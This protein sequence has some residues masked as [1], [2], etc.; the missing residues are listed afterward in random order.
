MFL[1]QLRCALDD[2]LATWSTSPE[3][4]FNVSFWRAVPYDPARP[5]READG[6]WYVALSMDG[7]NS[8]AA[9][10]KL[11]CSEGGQ[12]VLWRSPALRGPDADWQLAGPVLGE[13]VG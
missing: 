12:L 10:Q 6:N 4:L 5:W 13:H 2:D 9:L 1:A 8:T 7:C 11:P 3:Y